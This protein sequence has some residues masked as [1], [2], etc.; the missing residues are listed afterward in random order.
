MTKPYQKHLFICT[1][2]REGGGASCGNSQGGKF[3]QVAK[4]TF[5]E[6]FSVGKKHLYRVSS[7]G[8]LGKCA[9]GPVAVSYPDGAWWQIK[10]E[11]HMR[12]IVRNLE[13]D[14]QDTLNS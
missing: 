7:A 12:E 6:E 2:A 14:A 8:C 1:N 10:D 3:C 11:E 4:A 9:N 5:R 13:S